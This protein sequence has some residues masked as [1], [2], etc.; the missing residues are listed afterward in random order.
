MTFKI[1]SRFSPS[2]VRAAQALEA[3]IALALVP[4][5][6]KLKGMTADSAGRMI[7]D[8]GK[9]AAGVSYCTQY[10]AGTLIS[11]CMTELKVERKRVGQER[12]AR[13]ERLEAERALALELIAA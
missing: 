4:A 12:K 8:F 13:R 7:D 1:A 11:E 10:E 6:S 9:R 3:Y 5:D 2:I